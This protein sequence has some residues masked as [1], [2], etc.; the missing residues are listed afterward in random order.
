MAES[1]VLRS[2]QQHIHCCTCLLHHDY[3][4][5]AQLLAAVFGSLAADLQQYSAVSSVSNIT[6]Q[7]QQQQ[8]A[9]RQP[10][11]PSATAEPGAAPAAAAEEEAQAARHYNQ[12]FQLSCCLLWLWSQLMLYLPHD[13]ECF[14]VLMPCA[15]L[16]LAVLRTHPAAAAAALTSA[17][18]SSLSGCAVVRTAAVKQAAAA[19]QGLMQAQRVAAGWQEQLSNRQPGDDLPPLALAWASSDVQQLQLAHLARVAERLH[20]ESSS[21]SS[22][23]SGARRHE[24]AVSIQA[25]HQQLFA[26]LGIESEDEQR[27]QQHPAMHRGRDTPA[28]AL[29]VEVVQ[30]CAGLI[31]AATCHRD[32]IV[33]QQQQQ[34]GEEQQQQQQG[35]REAVSLQQQQQQQQ[36]E[37]EDQQQQHAGEAVLP[38]QEQQQQH[39]GDEPPR[40]AASCGSNSD[41]NSD[42]SDRCCSRQYAAALLVLLE[43]QQLLEADPAVVTEIMCLVPPFLQQCSVWLAEH[44]DMLLQL[45]SVVLHE[46]PAC[47]DRAFSKTGSSSSSSSS[48]AAAAQ[49]AAAIA[50]DGLK[51]AAWEEYSVVVQQLQRS[52]T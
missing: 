34:E 45:F 30:L 37:G 18:S 51:E 27:Q 40:P 44:P 29:A 19:A 48:S 49:V 13:S 9:Q 32:R 33:E 22:S 14:R 38:Q 5:F 35:P 43:L 20:A 4:G 7:Q 2:M 50:P 24:Q 16:P 47:L 21:S 6:S 23:S 28:K 46:V 42:S 26:T 31:G 8:S 1:S 25:W 3:A 41:D 10:D 39:Q 36:Q 15:A 11:K 52:G 12:V 17:S